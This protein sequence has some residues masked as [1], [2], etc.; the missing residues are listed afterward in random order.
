MHERQSSRRC[1]ASIAE[2]ITN[3]KE[4]IMQEFTVRVKDRRQGII[5]RANQLARDQRIANKRFLRYLQK[6]LGHRDFEVL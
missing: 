2:H 1:C 3:E 4:M 6:A 5:H